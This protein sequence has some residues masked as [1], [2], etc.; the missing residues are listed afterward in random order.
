MIAPSIEFGDLEGP[1]AVEFDNLEGVD[2]PLV[3]PIEM[4]DEELCD[5][6]LLVRQVARAPIKA[7]TARGRIHV[8]VG[9]ATPPGPIDARALTSSLVFLCG[10]VML[11]MEDTKC[12]IDE[13]YKRLSAA[14]AR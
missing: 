13:V 5:G 6:A 7:I 3:G 2:D 11:R 9:V 4:P 14:M 8:G 1:F 10:L 12:N